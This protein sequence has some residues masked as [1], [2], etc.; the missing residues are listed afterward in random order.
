MGMPHIPSK[1]RQEAI[2]DLLESIALEET[3]M[4]HI[5]NAEGE[6]LQK[7]LDCNFPS[8][9]SFQQVIELQNS[10]VELFDKL[11]QKQNILLS[12]LK[13]LKE[14]MYY[15]E[16]NHGHDDDDDHDHNHDCDCDH[17]HDYNHDHNPICD[18]E[19]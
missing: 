2:N 7:S 18:D 10:V 1:C 8:P 4:A 15:N 17:D 14:F 6:K 3:A 16:D 11:I 12:K 5:M 13:V 9:T 19:K